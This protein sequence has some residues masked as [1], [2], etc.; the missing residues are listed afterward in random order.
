MDYRNQI[1][2]P[3]KHWILYGHNMKNKSMFMSLLNYESKWYF[4]HHSYIEFDTL[5][6]KQTWQVF[7]AYLT[8]ESDDYIQTSFHTDSEYNGFLMDIRQRSLHTTNVTLSEND[9][10]L[11]LSTCSYVNEQARFVVHAKRISSSSH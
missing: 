5:Y 8:D 2:K 4:E 7:S 1:A 9:T 3:E 6:D 11:T 10:I